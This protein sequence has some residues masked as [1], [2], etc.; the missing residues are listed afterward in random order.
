MR[1]VGPSGC[2]GFGAQTPARAAGRVFEHL[3]HANTTIT[4]NLYVHLLRSAGGR[5]A[6][7]AVPR[8]NK[9]VPHRAR[10]DHLARSMYRAMTRNPW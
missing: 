9:S 8:A 5:A 2:Y 7:A 10:K 4:G 1:G 6:E 3:D